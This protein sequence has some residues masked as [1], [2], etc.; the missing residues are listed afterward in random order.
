VESEGDRKELA[1]CHA[2]C[3]DSHNHFAGPTLCIFLP[4][5]DHCELDFQYLL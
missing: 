5:G 3:L 1:S 2:A 4:D